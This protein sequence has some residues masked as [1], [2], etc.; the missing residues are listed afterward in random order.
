MNKLEIII[1]MTGTDKNSIRD[2]TD[3]HILNMIRMNTNVKKVKEYVPTPIADR[4]FENEM[5]ELPSE[6]DKPLNSIRQNNLN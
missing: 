4:E 5:E 1:Q 2:A 6:L 3:N